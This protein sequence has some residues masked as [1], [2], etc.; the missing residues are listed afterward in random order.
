MANSCEG[1]P[2]NCCVDFKIRS[3]RFDPKGL[4]EKLKQ[5]PFIKKVGTEPVRGTGGREVA[6]GVYRCDKF[7][8]KKG[9]CLIYDAE[10]PDFCVNTGKVIDNLDFRPHSKCIL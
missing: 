7:D 9:A 6:V 8:T 1:C 4:V 10:R 5:F 3:E 2:V